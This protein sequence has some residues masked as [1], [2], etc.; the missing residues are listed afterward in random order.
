L[1][2]DIFSARLTA[3]IAI[4]SILLLNL[5]NCYLC[6]KGI[7]SLYLYLLMSAILPMASIPCLT[8]LNSAIPKV[9]R[10]RIFS[11]CHGFG[12]M[13]ISSPKLK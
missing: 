8:L 10:Y 1:V 2:A 13:L 3:S 9:I 4:I 11:I 5:I 7:F 12:A 6:N